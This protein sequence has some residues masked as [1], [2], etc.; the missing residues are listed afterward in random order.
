M[1]HVVPVVFADDCLWGVGVSVLR[2]VVAVVVPVGGVVVVAVVVVVL[3]VAVGS[4]VSLVRCS[5]V[6]PV[7]RLV[8]PGGMVPVGPVEGVGVVCAVEVNRVSLFSGC[9]PPFFV[10]R[11]RTVVVSGVGGVFPV[12]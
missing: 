6:L 5:I 11:P 7:V 4:V 10:V 1:V 9:C 2:V 12:S 3:V 8:A